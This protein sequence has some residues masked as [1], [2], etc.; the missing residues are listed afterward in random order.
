MPG[1]G[2]R[3]CGRPSHDRSQARGR[4]VAGTNRDPVRCGLF[5][6]GSL[7]G[8]LVIGVLLRSRAVVRQR[9]NLTTACGVTPVSLAMSRRWP[10]SQTVRFGAPRRRTAQLPAA[11]RMGENAQG[12]HRNVDKG[13]GQRKHYRDTGNPTLARFS[14]SYLVECSAKSWEECDSLRIERTADDLLSLT[15]YRGEVFIRSDGKRLGCNRAGLPSFW[16]WFYLVF[17]CDQKI[18]RSP[19]S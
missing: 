7:P 8:L 15:H 11:D 1:F 9:D 18:W 6:E 19:L 4:Y 16:R 14:R 12:P 13:D 5:P 17:L 3:K 10:G 2:K